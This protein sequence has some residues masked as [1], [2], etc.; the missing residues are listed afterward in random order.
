VD[1]EGD[2]CL[3]DASFTTSVVKEMFATRWKH[4]GTYYGDTSFSHITLT[5]GAGDRGEHMLEEG[6]LVHRMFDSR[7][8]LMSIIAMFYWASLLDLEEKTALVYKRLHEDEVHGQFSIE[9]IRYA[10]ALRSEFLHFSSYWHFRTLTNKDEENEHFRRKCKAYNVDR[11]RDEI[12]KEIDRL[13][14]FITEFYQRRNTQA[15]NRLAV[16]SMILGGGAVL[17]GFFGMNFGYLF[18]EVF[19]EPE[20]EYFWVYWT[21]LAAILVFC[22]GG[23]SFSVYLIAAHWKDYQNILMPS[24]QEQDAIPLTYSVRKADLREDEEEDD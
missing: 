1:K 14:S 9:N 6:F 21:S 17:T 5:V 19:L 7:Y 11:K 3:Y 4:E 13:N 15:L 23:F 12:E 10:N 18:R 8:Y 22:V 16:L 24:R 2:G 20:S